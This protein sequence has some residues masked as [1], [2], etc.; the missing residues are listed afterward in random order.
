MPEVEDT[1]WGRRA[2]RGAGGGDGHAA[3]LA[4]FDLLTPALGPVAGYVVGY[5]AAGCVLAG[6]ARSARSVTRAEPALS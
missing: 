6:L 4:A 1:R 3:F 5:V 2:C